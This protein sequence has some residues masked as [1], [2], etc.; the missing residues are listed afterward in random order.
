MRLK[1][2]TVL[3][4][5]VITLAFNIIQNSSAFNQNDVSAI[6]YRIDKEWV[7]VWINEDASLEIHYNITITYESSALGYITIGLPT[8][9][10]DIHSVKDLSGT[11]LDPP[12]DVSSG[13]YYAVEIYFGHP[14]EPGDSG[15]VL[16]I[17]TVP[18]DPSF[19]YPDETN[20][21]NTAMTF[22]PTDF[23]AI[24]VNL[25]VAIVPPQGVT[26]DNIKTLETAYYTTVDGDFA[27]Y[28]E[29]NNIPQDTPLTFGVSIPEQYVT[30]PSMGPDIW[31]Y[32]AILSII[33]TILAVVIY[34]IRRKEVYEKPRIKIEALGP[35]RG[36]TAVEA[37]VVVGL[38]PIRVLTMILFGL[39]LKRFIMIKETEPLIKVERLQ[40]PLDAPT[41]PLR[42]YEIDFLKAIEPDNSLNERGMA[43]TYISL[44]DNVDKKMRGYAR[45]DTVNY[46]K[47]IVNNA[48]NQV[49]QANTPQ[50]TEET[51]EENLEW[52]L[53]DE[54]YRERF[55]ET[56][57]PD[58]LIIPRPYWYWYGPHFPSK[59]TTTSTGTTTSTEAKPIPAQEFADR[60][61][62]GI[63]EAAG[64]LV[65][66]AEDFA[67]RLIPPKATAQSSKPVRH[68]SSCVCACASCA[69]AC[70]CVSCACACASGGAR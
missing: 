14:M 9:D 59:R 39:L 3:F 30:I 24:T 25:R 27:V 31:F 23:D 7:T 43:R 21:G 55:K 26:K 18:Y 47:S 44:R 20:P 52:L 19:I 16:L 67:K 4:L 2:K 66:N 61:V 49:K 68:R 46:Y 36:L 65:K 29:H 62:T 35:A 8:K 54:K 11:I 12:R 56:L 13:N 17:A 6:Q 5:L 42:Y 1:H 53:L 63:E 38:K 10:F 60:I 48:W 32:F 28:W 64:G 50:L 57:K 70:A 15:T 69:C 40:K 33:V 34:L 51:I 58:I 22:V 41:R 45:N 37:A